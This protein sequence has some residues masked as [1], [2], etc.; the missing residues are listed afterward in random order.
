[1]NIPE[2]ISKVLLSSSRCGL[3]HNIIRIKMPKV[4]R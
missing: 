3:L 4:K 2:I 1:M